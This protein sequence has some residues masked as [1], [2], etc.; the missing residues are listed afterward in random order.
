MSHDMTGCYYEHCNRQEH[1]SA[2]CNGINIE[3]SVLA[4]QS[5]ADA[6]DQ[7]ALMVNPFLSPHQRQMSRAAP[8][9]FSPLE[10]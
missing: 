9:D 8:L 3:S 2:L 1:I 5:G 10:S 4:S 7:S 6:K